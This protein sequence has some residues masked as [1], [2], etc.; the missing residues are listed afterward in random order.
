MIKDFYGKYRPIERYY[1]IK[2][3]EVYLFKHVYRENDS[4]P[5]NLNISE[6]ETT[7]DANSDIAS[8]IDIINDIIDD[9][10]AKSVS[11]YSSINSINSFNS[12][13]SDFSEYNYL[14]KYNKSVDNPNK[15]LRR[16]I[17]LYSFKVNFLL[18][19]SDNSIVDK[20]RL[21]INNVFE[22]DLMSQLNNKR[23][24]NYV[25]KNIYYR[26]EN[27]NKLIHIPDYTPPKKNKNNVYHKLRMGKF[28]TICIEVE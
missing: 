16:L 12:L 26:E 2:L 23:N 18:Y 21:R 6:Y 14:N 3:K 1:K 9:D 25:A 10:D 20:F 24:T 19:R 5:G 13:K 28:N 22:E 27:C 7:T 4:G 11:S 17:M 15:R 8:E